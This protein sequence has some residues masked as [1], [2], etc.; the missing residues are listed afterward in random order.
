M[1][2]VYVRE[3]EPF[4]R[5]VKSFSKI[6]ERAGLI[7]D[8]KKNRYFEKPSEIKKRKNNAARRKQIREDRRKTWSFR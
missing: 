4:E 5:A 7:S 8:I 1:N 2:G 3:V 6:C